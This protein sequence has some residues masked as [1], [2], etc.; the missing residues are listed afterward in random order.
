MSFELIVDIFLN[1]TDYLD[2]LFANYSIWAY[3]ILFLIIFLE[4]GIVI[5]PFL[6]GDS[7]L[8]AVGAIAAVSAEVNGFI[9]AS[10]LAVA[11]ILG[12]TANYEIGSSLSNKVLSDEKIK[13]I[14]KEYIE[15]T[16]SFFDRHGGKTITISRFIPI[17]R[18][19]APFVAGATKMQYRK[20]FTY[21]LVG[22]VLWVCVMFGIGFFFGNIPAV[23]DNFMLVAI[24]IVVISLIPAVVTFLKSRATGKKRAVNE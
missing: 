16:R 2:M 23:K 18:T 8:F 12:D 5:T 13:F 10:I 6:P 20:F 19:F 15:R 1:T 21:N 14:K 17:I 3:V 4:T 7:I 11:A 22:G 9:L 24:G